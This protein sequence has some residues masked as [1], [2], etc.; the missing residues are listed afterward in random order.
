M[1]VWALAMWLF[2][3]FP[4]NRVY[5][6]ASCRLWGPL[7]APTLKSSGKS[8]RRH[9]DRRTESKCKLPMVDHDTLCKQQEEKQNRR[10]HVI[11]KGF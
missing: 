6:S 5:G 11:G 9:A 3:H 2:N 4:Y 1:N 10:G 8:S 7:V